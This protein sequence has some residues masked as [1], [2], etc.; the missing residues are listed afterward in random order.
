MRRRLGS[1]SDLILLLL[2]IVTLLTT[3]WMEHLTVANRQLLIWGEKPTDMLTNG[4]AGSLMFAHWQVAHLGAG[5]TVALT[6]TCKTHVKAHSCHLFVTPWTVVCQSPLSIEFFRQEYWSG[7]PFPI[8]GNLPNLG[9][10]L[11]YPVSPTLAGRFFTP[12]GTWEALRD[13]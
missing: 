10:E 4:W 13:H 3:Y 7:L 8:P 2:M 1:T 11:M 6:N 12:A 5:P 9:I